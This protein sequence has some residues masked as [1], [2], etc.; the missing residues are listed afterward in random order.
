MRQNGH[1]LARFCPCDISNQTDLSGGDQAVDNKAPAARQS[2]RKHRDLLDLQPGRE[3]LRQDGSG[4]SDHPH[5]SQHHIGRRTGAAPDV[6]T[7]G[8]RGHERHGDCCADWI[9]S[10]PRDMVV[11]GRRHPGRY[12]SAIWI[13]RRRA[14]FGC[15]ASR[16]SSARRGGS[17]H[18]PWVHRQEI[19]LARDRDINVN[20]MPRRDD[21]PPSPAVVPECGQT[22]STRGRSCWVTSAGNARKPFEPAGSSKQT[23]KQS[24]PSS[25]TAIL[26]SAAAHLIAI[27]IAAVESAQQTISPRASNDRDD[28]A[29]N[30]ARVT[31]ARECRLRD[32]QS[33]GP[34][35][36]MCR[37]PAVVALTTRGRVSPRPR[38]AQASPGRQRASKGTAGFGCQQRSHAPRNSAP[39]RPFVA[40]AANANTIMSRPPTARCARRRCKTGRGILAKA[41]ADG[42]SK[43][44]HSRPMR[45]KQ[46]RP[47]PAARMSS[48]P[49][50]AR[51]HRLL[52]RFC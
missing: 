46:K 5:H 47:R 4:S 9:C 45:S 32:S 39:V 25:F 19:S 6:P 11:C 10:G 3:L 43:I 38:N 52:T 29:V 34:A 35:C 15:G 30:D 27:W 49:W 37:R 12:R 2:S 50:P 28:E 16:T 44:R 18:S 26:S 22:L 48:P 24:S 33:H 41:K 23:N 51:N 20:R 17:G 1:H 31:D 21:E 7:A 42:Q 13:P 14:R 40:R 8:S 36:S